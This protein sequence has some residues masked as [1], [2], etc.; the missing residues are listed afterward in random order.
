[1]KNRKI[2][3]YKEVYENIKQ[4]E[5][6]IEEGIENDPLLTNT[7]N[8]DFS[9]NVLKSI[10]RFLEFLKTSED[11]E[12]ETYL[13]N[14]KDIKKLDKTYNGLY[15][16]NVPN[17]YS[18]YFVESHKLFQSAEYKVLYV[19]RYNVEPDF[20]DIK[21]R[22]DDTHEYKRE[23]VLNKTQDTIAHETGY[24]VVLG[25]AGT[26]KTDVAMYTYI[27][28]ID[29]DNNR[30]NDLSFVT[31]SNK[32]AKYVTDE[33]DVILSDM[34]IKTKT[35]VFTTASFFLNVLSSNN[36]EI[37]GYNLINGIYTKG[38]SKKAQ[39]SETLLN[40]L[41]SLNT[42]DTWIK[43][44][45]LGLS[46]TTLN[47]L[48]KI[49][50]K[51]GINYPYLFFRGIYQGKVINKVTEEDTINYLDNIYNLGYQKTKVLIS[52]LDDY[53]E[54]TEEPSLEDFETWY[55]TKTSKFK[56]T[57]KQLNNLNTKEELYKA[58]NTYYNYA[59]P[60]K[61]DSRFIDS[62]DLF[63][64]EC[65]LIEGYRGEVR[66]NFIDE[67]KVMYDTFKSFR[68]YLDTN[69][70]YTD[71][72]L[73]Y[74]V[75]S[76][77]DTILNKGIYK[78]IVI[79]EFQDMTERE[80]HA[81][82]RLN[83][84]SLEYGVIHMFGDFEQTINPTFIQYESIETLFMINSV[85]KYK[86]QLL[87]TTYRYSSAI[88]KELEALREKGKNLFGLED[89]SNYVPLT[90][91]KAYQFETSGNLV[92]NK[93]IGLKM[94]EAITK[95]KNDNIMYVVANDLVKKDFILKYK[96]KEDSVFTV[97]D[98]KGMESEFVVVYNLCTSSSKEF[99]N[100]FSSDLSYSRASRIF[101][102]QLYVGLTRC[103]TNFIQIEDETLLGVN[104]K[105]ALKELI[106]VLNDNNV[107]I[108]LE[109]ML[110][111]KINYYFRA[112]ESF[113]GLDFE[114]TKENLAFYT[115][116]DYFYLRDIL[117]SIDEYNETRNDDK[118][119]TYANKLKDKDRLDLVRI[120]YTV[121]DRTNL[122]LILDIREKNIS[123]NDTDV[124]DIIK[125]YSKY[126]DNSDIKALEKSLYFER[127]KRELEYKIDN[128]KIE[129]IK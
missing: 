64:R 115:G 22:L 7:F 117:N 10:T 96:V 107:D 3:L 54:Y 95:S 8:K 25:A 111:L 81:I 126:L 43:D 18:M 55:N 67:I 70:L 104:T 102:N 103:K 41:V 114:S 68:E 51:Y 5:A 85:E 2:Y 94:I 29:L 26:G 127:R 77:L 78:N 91:N 112:L 48:K 125:N 47:E 105:T 90:S 62:F 113:K 66:D 72:D 79:D 129:V 99:E 38:M 4:R 84:N 16:Y 13:A 61:E 83:Y 23:Y 121:I 101:Y 14:S 34:H 71:N 73:A 92:L 30:I 50:D 93:E 119:V 120:I 46:K 9:K 40:N 123:Y 1:M 35:N 60:V 42:F 36:I 21:K 69:N 59:N 39:D 82:I 89:L 15:S 44:G 98:S 27:N 108:F 124:S 56:N 17:M 19:E 53:T 33:L 122:L 6:H 109:E 128:L 63:K 58:F 75:T 116:T 57:F 118:L 87:T 80:I 74:I 31:Y 97:K 28:N 76:N 106:P 52:L 49:I 37:K 88:C 12:L 65:S 86:K 110:S 100:L 45:A 11:K 24:N 32:L 20:S